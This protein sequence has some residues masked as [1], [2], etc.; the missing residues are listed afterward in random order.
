MYSNL[1]ICAFYE[2]GVALI[3]KASGPSANPASLVSGEGSLSGSSDSKW[4]RR[5]ISPRIIHSSIFASVS[6]KQLRLPTNRKNKK[7]ST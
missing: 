5:S 4:K 2:T 6:P 7:N 3:L 1:Y